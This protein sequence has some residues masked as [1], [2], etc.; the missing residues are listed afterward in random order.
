[1]KLEER[2]TCIWSWRLGCPILGILRTNGFMVGLIVFDGQIEVMHILVPVIKTGSR[3]N[4]RHV[5]L[6]F[7]LFLF[8]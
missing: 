3:L 5:H 8:I 4:H 1:M 2:K 6:A 7:F